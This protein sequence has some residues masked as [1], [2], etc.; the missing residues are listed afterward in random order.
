L[1]ALTIM[2]VGF[3]FG[4]IIGYFLHKLIA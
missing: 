2:A 4:Q 3:M 1:G